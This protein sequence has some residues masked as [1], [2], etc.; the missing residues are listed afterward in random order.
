MIYAVDDQEFF[1]DSL[2]IT[3]GDRIK[4]FNFPNA[5]LI[6]MATDRPSLLITDVFMPLTK[7]TKNMLPRGMDGLKLVEL[8][9]ATL[10]N[11][12]IIVV[13][14]NERSEIEKKYPGKLA[15]ISYFF[16]KPLKDDFYKLVEKLE[17]AKP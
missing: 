13:S 9:Q 10:P 11:T 14:G 12:K 7:P 4:T 17:P 2:K 6:S 3:F 15:K 16:N 8:V 5:A 1:L